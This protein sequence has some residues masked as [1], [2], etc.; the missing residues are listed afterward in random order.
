MA[1]LK[2]I[3]FDKDGTLIDFHASWVGPMRRLALDVAAGDAALAEELLVAIGYNR[4]TQRVEGDSVLA[5]GN[6]RDLAE[7]WLPYLPGNDV[8]YLIEKIE[9]SAVEDGVM[10][11]EPV[12]PLAPFFE[13]LRQSGLALGIATHDSEAGALGLVRRCQAEHLLDFVSGYDSGHG[14][15]SGPGMA[16]AFA[17]KVGAAPETLAVVGDNLTDLMMGRSAG[18]ALSIAVLTGTGEAAS[19]SVFADAVLPSIAGLKPWLLE[20][21]LI[22]P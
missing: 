8:P 1:K 15:K 12:L 6:I 11:A 3:L 14:S 7:A 20:Q 13:S 22:D 5:A 21:G 4:Q 10:G 9:R 19:L 17:E 16:L 2:G 18:Y